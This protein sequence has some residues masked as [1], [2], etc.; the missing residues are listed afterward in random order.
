MRLGRFSM[1]YHN[2][3]DP[4]SAQPI[5]KKHITHKLGYTVLILVAIALA[6]VGGSYYYALQTE[7]TA[8]KLAY[9]S[10]ADTLSYTVGELNQKLS[11]VEAQNNDLMTLLQAKQTENSNYVA[12]V[13][14][15]SNTVLELDKLSKTDRELLEK[16]SS[17]YFLNENYV[18]SSLG[19]IDSRYLFVTTKPMQIH[20]QVSPHLTR[21]LDDARGNGIDI[22]VLSGYRS[23]ASQQQLKSI[24]KITYGSGTA[25]SFSADQGY[26]E[27]QLGSTIDFTN[28]KSGSSLAGFDKTPAFP[29]LVE[30]AYRYG[31]IMSYPKGN[32]HFVYEPWHWRFVGIALATKLHDEN[33]QFYDLDQREINDYLGKIFDAN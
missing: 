26:S 11:A 3:M 5:P 22:S 6:C 19:S 7:L 18:P 10:S 32:T 2:W 13:G 20:A 27:H 8:T 25:N 23:F 31:F 29:W 21:L 15:L 24:Y 12:Q 33:K 30:H 28:A 4:I 9:Q 17:V 14:Q 16:Y 1:C